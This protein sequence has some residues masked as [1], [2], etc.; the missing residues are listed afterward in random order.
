M[1]LR[2]CC[3]L[4]LNRASSVPAT[5]PQFTHSLAGSLQQ[6][7]PCCSQLAIDMPGQPYLYSA[8]ESQRNSV[9]YPYSDFNPRAAT[10]A[11]Y[12]AFQE[13]AERQKR[14]AAQDGRPLINFN[15]HPDSYMIVANPTVHHEPLPAHT[16]SAIIWA[17]WIQFVFR[18]L[19]EIG[20]LGILVCVICLKMEDE[21]PSYVIRVA[22]CQR[23]C[24]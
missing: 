15:Q 2:S 21:G 9:A 17:R 11:H 16:K 14:N 23:N 20:A 12:A 6:Q 22:V 8:V 7:Q 5:T 19:Q 13:R 1:L 24:A 3:I 10:Q 18:L 4:L